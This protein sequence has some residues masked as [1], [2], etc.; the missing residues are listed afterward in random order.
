M[1]RREIPVSSLGAC[2]APARGRSTVVFNWVT[3]G[4]GW[5]G[6]ETIVPVRETR[7]AWTQRVSASSIV[8]AISA[9]VGKTFV[10]GGS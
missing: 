3:R 2:S 1:R 6:V 10:G 5:P 9:L 8:R 7:A 4:D